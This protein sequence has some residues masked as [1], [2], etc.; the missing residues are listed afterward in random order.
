MSQSGSQDQLRL[1]VD[2]QALQ[3]LVLR[4][5]RLVDRKD[6]DRLAALYHPDGRQDHGAMFAG[7]AADFVAWLKRSM[8]DIETQHLVANSLF[9]VDGDTA[10][11]EIYTV[12]FHHFPNTGM[13]YV[14]GGRY[15][16]RY[17]RHHGQWLFLSRT[18]VIDWSEERPS[19]P[20]STASTVLRGK[21]WSDDASQMLTPFFD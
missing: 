9:V 4:Y 11:G 1:L 16:D 20:G 14:A 3:E 18:R 5:S 19:Q 13:N 15:L 7:T 2:K 10:R 6:F 12:N 8:V 17:V 21:A